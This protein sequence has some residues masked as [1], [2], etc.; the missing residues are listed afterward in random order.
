VNLLVVL[1]Q[2]V[3]AVVV[4]VGRPHH[5]VN[6]ALR[7]RLIVQPDTG[8]MIEF[9]HQDGALNS[10]IERVFFAVS[11]D[12]APV[13]CDAAVL[14][15]TRVSRRGYARALA[16]TELTARTA[17]AFGWRH[18]HPLLQRIE[19]LRAPAPTRGRRVVG[20]VLSLVLMLSGAYVVWTARPAAPPDVIQGG[21]RGEYLEMSRSARQH[22]SQD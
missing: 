8:M 22:H 12:P 13:A 1:P 7:G 14:R 9:E 11:A 5:R 10:I 21:H 20:Y 6:V 2:Q 4:S 15:Q 18:R 16:K 3:L 17:I 19:I